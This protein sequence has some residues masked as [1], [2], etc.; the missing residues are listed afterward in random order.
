VPATEINTPFISKKK[1]MV[2]KGMLIGRRIF[3]E[4][5][6]LDRKIQLR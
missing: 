4:K 1:E 6:P 5:L 2:Y 3:I